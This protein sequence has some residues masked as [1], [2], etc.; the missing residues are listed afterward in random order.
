MTAQTK[1]LL[2]GL[3]VAA[4]IGYAAYYWYTKM[5]KDSAESPAG[6][7]ASPAAPKQASPVMQVSNV[8]SPVSGLTADSILKLGD[9]GDIVV[10]V[11]NLLNA[12]GY[13]GANGQKLETTSKKV[14]PQTLYAMNQANLM[15]YQPLSLNGMRTAIAMANGNNVPTQQQSSGFTYGNRWVTATNPTQ[16][17][18]MTP[19][20]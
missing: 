10:A 17:D 19:N 7:N 8:Q 11:Q 4:V 1:N 20:R 16:P 3:L 15:K 14:G 6:S 2:I 13:K 9:K 12:N 18:W 5:P